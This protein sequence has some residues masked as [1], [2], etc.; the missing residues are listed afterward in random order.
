MNSI[1]FLEILKLK[2]KI[3]FGSDDRIRNDYFQYK[4]KES[5]Y[6]K[7]NNNNNNNNIKDRKSVEQGKEVDLGIMSKINTLTYTP[8]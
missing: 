2:P 5:M 1:V 4:A 6:N 3:V 8:S 7:L